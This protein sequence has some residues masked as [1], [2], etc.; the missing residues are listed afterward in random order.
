M[1]AEKREFRRLG[2]SASERQLKSFAKALPEAADCRRCRSRI[3]QYNAMIFIPQFPSQSGQ[4]NGILDP[5]QSAKAIEHR[6]HTRENGT[7]LLP[8]KQSGKLFIKT[9][10]V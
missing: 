9:F 8:V 6:I 3:E 5:S 1:L 10:E 4:N 2:R 7:I